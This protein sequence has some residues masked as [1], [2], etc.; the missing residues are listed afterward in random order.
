LSKSTQTAL[1]VL[2]AIADDFLTY[3]EIADVCNLHPNTVKQI[4]YA[5][6]EGG[7]FIDMDS[8]EALSPKKRGGRPS[9]FSKLKKFDQ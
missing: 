1:S 4:L 3:E 2:E 6:S 7:I 5:L 8:K 9:N